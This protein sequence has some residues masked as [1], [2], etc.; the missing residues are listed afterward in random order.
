LEINDALGLGIDQFMGSKKI[1]MLNAPAEYLQNR[2]TKLAGLNADIK[3]DYDVELEK[4]KELAPGYEN[5]LAL[6]TPS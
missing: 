1:A 5:S 2:N 3:R 6:K 4:I